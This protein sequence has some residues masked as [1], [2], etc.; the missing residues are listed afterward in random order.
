MDLM[1]RMWE[2]NYMEK[3]EKE[4][5]IIYV[6]VSS[7]E[8]IE[9]TSL[10]SQERICKEYAEKENI[11]ILKIF[12]E[13][14]E[15][16][17]TA[18]RTEFMK[19]ISFCSE[20]KNKISSFIVYKIDRFS[21][22]QTDYAIVKQKLKK[23]GTEI[24]SV[25]EKIDD[26]PSGKLMEVMLSGFAE[27]DNNVRTERSVNGMRERL[28]QGVWVWPA[29]IGY[30]RLQKGDN[31]SLDPKFA[32][33]I[34][35]IFEEYAKG[36][37]TYKSLAEYIN[38]QGFTTKRG[39]SAIPQLIEKIIK[40]PLYAGI[41]KAW[42]IEAKG[43]FEPII[44]E[45]LFYQC[46]PKGKTRRNIPHKKINDKFPLRSLAI[47]KFC[48]KPLTGSA[49]TSCTGKKYSYYH[50][51]KQDC[52]H[53]KFI[54]KENFEQ[55]FVEFLNE[56]TPSVEYENAFK[57]IV[58]DIWK[59]NCKSFHGNN[60]KI[61][62]EITNLEKQKERIFELHESKVYDN[63][64]FSYQKNK[65]NQKIALQRSLIQEKIEEGFNMEEA[66]EYCFNFVRE[67]SK[68]WV[69]LGKQ[70]EKRLQFQKIIFEENI[71]FSGE[72][73]GTK[74]L[75]PIYSLYQQYLIDP[76]SLVTPQ[77]IEL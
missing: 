29:P 22:N 60:Q 76:S 35:L 32:P 49:S 9:G 20:K 40:N 23:Y 2:S 1:R 67:T 36:T 26:S 27:F 57:K 12:I 75:S 30:T 45:H 43:K 6:R 39:N 19:A 55:L 24:R 64:D 77:R 71:E 51:H 54:P 42:G 13:K 41:I 74:K 50:H 63:D 14:G 11:N 16:A 5:G 21:R 34:R 70:P 52:P 28:K 56:I 31:L 59:N 62:N 25:S 46:Q 38:K 66:L 8:Q 47:C 65:I 61:R 17:K 18:N 44:D 33:F 4:N 48:T 68:T 37:Y 72:K 15:S 73:F 3:I 69:D 10:D 7:H 58:M 53:S